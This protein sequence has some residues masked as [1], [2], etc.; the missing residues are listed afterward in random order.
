MKESNTV[1]Q[2][3]NGAQWGMISII[4]NIYCM[5]IHTEMEAPIKVGGI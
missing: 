3:K 1:R 4:L 5:Y 2:E